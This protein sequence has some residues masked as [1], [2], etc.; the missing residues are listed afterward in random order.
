MSMIQKIS[1]DNSNSLKGITAIMVVIHH[2]AQSTLHLKYLTFFFWIGN[3]TVGLF[4]FL[5]A[6]GLA[7]Q[8]GKHEDY[9]N[10]FWNKRIHKLLIPFLVTNVFFIL[11]EV[12]FNH[13][14]YTFIKYIYYFTGLKLIDPFAW[15]IPVIFLLYFSFWFSFKF[16]KKRLLQFGFIFFV[17]FLYIVHEVLNHH[18]GFVSIF[19]F[20][21]GV[22]Y[23][24]NVGKKIKLNDTTLGFFFLVLF[25][26]LFY[27][28]TQLQNFNTVKFLLIGIFLCFTYVLAIVFFTNKWSI[29]N[30]VFLF[31]GNISLEIYLIH[32]IF[33]SY[34]LRE[35]EIL[36]V[37]VVV[38]LS[39]LAAYVIQ[40]ID[41]Q[42]E[43]FLFK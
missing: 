21:L 19:C 7:I 28:T 27:L 2:I 26:I 40:K 16:F 13:K 22:F 33:T 12:L 8:I 6:Y 32:G 20:P 3:I 10:N 41:N 24:Q 31:L 4:F 30:K 25:V 35:N 29:K 37:A 38:P 17:I 43:K 34:L 9:L 36:A 1:V 23:A 11:F 14:S 5:S 15:Y 42:I 18:S 39:I